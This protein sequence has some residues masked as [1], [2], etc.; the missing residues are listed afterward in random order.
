[1]GNTCYANSLIQVLI[2]SYIFMIKLFNDNIINKANSLNITKKFYD[3]INRI[4]YSNNNN[5]N[6][7]NISDLLYLFDIK[8]PSY[9]ITNQNDSQEFCRIL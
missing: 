9:K 6:Y 4:C 2:H 5:E 3:I 8:H 7:I 1:M